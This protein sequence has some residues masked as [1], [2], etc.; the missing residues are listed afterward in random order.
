MIY[1]IP[2]LACTQ[3]L[4]YF[5]FRSF[6]KHRRARKRGEHASEASEREKEFFFPTPTPLRCRSI[7]PP[8]FI[9]YHACST[10]FEEKIEGLW[11]GYPKA[12]CLAF[13]SMNS[14]LRLCFGIH[15]ALGRKS[16]K[17]ADSLEELFTTR[18]LFWW[19]STIVNLLDIWLEKQS[20]G[21]TSGLAQYRPNII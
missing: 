16:E 21:K 3:T 8:R 1:T 17:Y 6:G 5:S 18:C 12:Q 10:D 11:T 9:F 20:I 14:V 15:H 2:K 7:T 19:V 13:H 4:F